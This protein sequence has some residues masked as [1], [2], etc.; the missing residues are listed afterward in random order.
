M[1]T[2][3]I[4]VET[5]QYTLEKKKKERRRRKVEE[6]QTV[7]ILLL[8]YYL[9]LQKL[10]VGLAWPSFICNSIQCDTIQYVQYN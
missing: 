9:F 3:Y 2:Q 8:T 5:I 6:K 7:L 1:H 10:T 4:R